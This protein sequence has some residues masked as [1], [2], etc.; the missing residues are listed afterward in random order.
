VT[1]SIPTN[2]ALFMSLAPA[3]RLG[4][5]TIDLYQIHA[6]DALTPVEETLRALEHLV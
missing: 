5:N 2:G 6:L 3:W 4:T 1:K